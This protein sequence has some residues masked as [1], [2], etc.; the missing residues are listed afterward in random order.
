V[1]RAPYSDEPPEG[2]IFVLTDGRAAVLRAGRLVP[3]VRGGFPHDAMATE[4]IATR[5]AQ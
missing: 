4:P 5:R 2:A 1:I 3:I